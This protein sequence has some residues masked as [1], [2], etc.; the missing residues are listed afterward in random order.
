M[1]YADAAIEMMPPLIISFHI[2][3]DY[4]MLFHAIYV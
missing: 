4:V 1:R 2:T 3:N